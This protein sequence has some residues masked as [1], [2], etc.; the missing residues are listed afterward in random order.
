MGRMGEV[1]TANTRPGLPPTLWLGDCRAPSGSDGCPDRHRRNEG[2]TTWGHGQ[3]RQFDSAEPP[4]P[5][6]PIRHG[7]LPAL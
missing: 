7:G 6:G 1:L 4:A 2:R 3:Y 5:V